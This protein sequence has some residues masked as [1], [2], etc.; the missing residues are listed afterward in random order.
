MLNVCIFEGRLTRDVNYIDFEYEGKEQ[1]MAVVSIAVQK[2]FKNAQGKRGANYPD[3]KVFGNKI[4]VLKSFKK[5]D[6]IGFECEYV[7]KIVETDQTESG[8]R[9][10]G[11][12]SAKTIHFPPN[13]NIADQEE[14]DEYVDIEEARKEVGIVPKEDYKTKEEPRVDDSEDELPF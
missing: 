10:E 7:T 13:D 11:Y 3:I 2:N 1:T 6:Y 9:K 5:G 8:M 4:K 12:F 14:E